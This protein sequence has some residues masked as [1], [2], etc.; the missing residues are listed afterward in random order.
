MS[1]EK[2]KRNDATVVL[3]SDAILWLIAAALVAIAVLTNG[4]CAA[5]VRLEKVHT[6]PPV[7]QAEVQ[8]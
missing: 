4:G 3:G 2:K 8:K 7:V 6:P 5:S 1:D